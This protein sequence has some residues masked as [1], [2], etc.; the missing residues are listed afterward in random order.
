VTAQAC[1]HDRESLRRCDACRVE[2][3]L[4][5][6]LACVCLSLAALVAALATY[7]WD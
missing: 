7:G 4:L 1:P 5:A 3:A 2:V 6:I